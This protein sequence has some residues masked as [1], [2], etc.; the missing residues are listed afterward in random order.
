M[1]LMGVQA[2]Q[3]NSETIQIPRKNTQHNKGKTNIKVPKEIANLIRIYCIFNQITVT[4]FA[5]KIFEREL[6]DFKKKLELMK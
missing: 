6:E 4:D 2:I 5:T 1:L 3:T